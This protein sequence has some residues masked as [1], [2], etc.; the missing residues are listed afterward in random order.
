MHYRISKRSK[1]ILLNVARTSIEDFLKYGKTKKFDFKE[2]D[3]LEI[4]AVFVTL[5]ERDSGK[6]RGCIGNTNAVLSLV[7]E[8]SKNAISSAVR[9][10]RFSPLKKNQI[11]NIKIEI[12][13][14]S[15]FKQILPNEIVI[16][17][18]GLYLLSKSHSSLFLPEVAISQ[19]W[20]I[21]DFL[22]E[23]S[24][25]AGL[26]KEEWKNSETKLFGFE[27]ESWIEH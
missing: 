7:E 16:G 26:S 20:N 17:K 15:P 1:E 4:R 14:L 27:S 8:V 10:S 13:V 11:K 24:L 6:L 3:L 22:D 12:N 9:D 19:G 2:D 5:W 25:K 23:L 21:I 18:H